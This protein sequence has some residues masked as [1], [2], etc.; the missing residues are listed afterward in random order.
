[1][2]CPFRQGGCIIKQDILIVL[3]PKCQPEHICAVLAQH[4]IAA[5]I[6][7]DI[8]SAIRSLE[9]STKA[10]LLLDLSLDGADL[11]LDEI[12]T[13]FY[14]PPPYLLVAND[15]SDNTERISILNRG[16]DACLEK[17]VEAGEVLAVINA[18]LRRTARTQRTDIKLAPC[19]T[20]LDLLIDP[21]RR[22]VVMAGRKIDLTTKEFD[23]LYLLASY[24]G[25][26]FSK[27]QIYQHVWNEDYA[28]ATTSVT[29]R[30]SSIRRKL[31]LSIKDKRYIQTVYDAGYRFAPD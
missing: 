18:A 5:T 13:N 12:V 6:A 16:A 23:I 22:T 17:P 8:R 10:F 9:Q 11:F 21:L 20:H 14:N 31:G 29:D 26:V 7:E 28:Y 24:P 27:A 15:F 19:I 25:L 30:I 2:V 1:M 4:G 3:S